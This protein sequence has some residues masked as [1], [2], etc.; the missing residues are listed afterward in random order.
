MSVLVLAIGAFSA[1][2]LVLRAFERAC[3]RFGYRATLFDMLPCFV[4][5]TWLVVR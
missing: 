4:V 2:Y 5:F 1:L 3:R